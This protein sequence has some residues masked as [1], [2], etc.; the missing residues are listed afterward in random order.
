LQWLKTFEKIQKGDLEKI[1]R[2]AEALGDFMEV[3]QV[4]LFV[5]S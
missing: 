2:E 4:K 5:M 1:R 3:S